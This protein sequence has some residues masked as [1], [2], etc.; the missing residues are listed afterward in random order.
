MPNPLSEFG[1][2]DIDYAMSVGMT[3]GEAMHEGLVGMG[4]IAATALNRAQNPSTYLSRSAALGDVFSAPFDAETMV[5]ATLKGRSLPAAGRQFSP[6]FNKDI[7]GASPA[8]FQNFKSGLQAALKSA[9]DPTFSPALGI[10]QDSYMR[11]QKAVEVAVKARDLGID[12]GLGVE[13]FS[14]PGFEKDAGVGRNR[15]RFGGHSLS[16]TGGWPA[17]VTAP[18]S[19][20][21]ASRFAAA[22]ALTGVD[23]PDDMVPDITA[24]VSRGDIMAAASIVQREAQNYL[25]KDLGQDVMPGLNYSDLVQPTGLRAVDVPDVTGRLGIDPPGAL[26]FAENFGITPTDQFGPVTPADPIGRIEASSIPNISPASAGFSLE[27]FSPSAPASPNF[28]GVDIGSYPDITAG[29]YSNPL[30][31]FTPVDAAP[32]D[33]SGVRQGMTEQQA[34]DRMGLTDQRPSTNIEVRHGS[35]SYGEDIDKAI[36]DRDI[37]AASWDRFANQNYDA[38]GSVL[39]L[40]VPERQA[41]FPEAP[42]VSMNQP[43][44]LYG[45]FAP[46]SSITAGILHDDLAGFTA[47]TPA[48]PDFSDLQTPAQPSG[49]SAG[50]GEGPWGVTPDFDAPSLAARNAL[51]RFEGAMAVR[52]TTAPD[53]TNE[54]IAGRMN[55]DLG[56]VSEKEQQAY[57]RAMSEYNREKAQYDRDLA[58]YNAATKSFSATPSGFNTDIASLEAPV[59]SGLN[60]FGL[61]GF[62]N[63]TTGTA[64][65]PAMAPARLSRPTPPTRPSA[66]VASA[67]VAAVRSAP[68]SGAP[69]GW[70]PGVGPDGWGGYTTGVGGLAGLDLDNFGKSYENY[71]N[72]MASVSPTTTSSI[73]PFGWNDKTG[74]TIGGYASPVDAIKDGLGFSTKPDTSFMDAMANPDIAKGYHPGF[75]DKMSSSLTSGWSTPGLIGGALGL[76]TGGPM[77]AF[78]GYQ[79]GKFGGQA[80]NAIG[81][82]F[83]GNTGF[84]DMLGGIFGG[85]AAGWD[86]W[87]AATMGYGPGYNSRGERSPTGEDRSGN[88]TVGDGSFSE[89][90]GYNSNS[91][92]GIL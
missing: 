45:E 24:H 15:S 29:L 81:D 55:A 75:M 7:R 37:D 39:G 65:G 32:V 42:Y 34:I 19:K 89:A 66:P 30:D 47:P 91:P 18:T 4:L 79:T 25:S 14:A 85:P 64:V 26:G 31:S 61:S 56:R 6:T 74:L 46:A 21:F 71:M 13:H 12:L 72:E 50:V 73:G 86:N 67:P 92:Q 80:F 70:N 48:T 8:G 49:F 59:A 35:R 44:D 53:M 5:D 3:M 43:Y 69:E 41:S 60:S 40:S 88:A 68:T 2:S 84:G 82:L 62:T 27:D 1:V 83:G 11:A 36:E 87:D 22:A 16:P 78:M 57:E 28:S 20:D 17:G 51:D 38:F 10:R 54:A 52:N 90:A 77:G 63:P 33:F 23:I 76:V 9:Y 58:A